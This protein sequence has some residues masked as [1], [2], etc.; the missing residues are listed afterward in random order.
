MLE[1]RAAI[2]ALCLLAFLAHAAF[3]VSVRSISAAWAN[4]PPVPSEE[5][6]V[7][8]ALGD[9]QLAYRGIGLMLQ[10]LGDTGGRTTALADYDYEKLGQW[11]FLEDRLDQKSNYIPFLAAYYFGGTPNAEDLDPIIEYL[12]MI[13]QRP[14]A[15]KWRWLGQAVYLSRFRQQD[16]D[17]AMGLAHILAGMWHPGMPGWTRQMPAFVAMQQ[18]DKVAAYAIMTN[19][20]KEE[21]DSMHPNE[22]NFMVGYICERLLAPSEA[23]S[24]PLCKSADQR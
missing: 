8:L 19:I 2:F 5:S 20:L 6:A 18:G 7:M 1:R 9:G 14:Y 10:N 11:F 16:L 23:A 15:Q 17:K 13:G 24:H 4:V 12:A 22:V 3:S 21:A